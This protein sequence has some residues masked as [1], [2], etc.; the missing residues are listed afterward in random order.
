MF[1]YP[2]IISQLSESADAAE[3]DLDDLMADLIVF[4]FLAQVQQNFDE[5][6]QLADRDGLVSASGDFVKRVIL[7]VAH[8]TAAFCGEPTEQDDV[9]LKETKH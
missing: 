1:K 7:A 9:I 4:A 5:D 8:F 2:N 3:A 6:G